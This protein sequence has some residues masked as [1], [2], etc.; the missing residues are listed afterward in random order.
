MIGV[1]DYLYEPAGLAL[2]VFLILFSMSFY[3]F[4]Y[5][6]KNKGTSVLISLILSILASWQLYRERFYGWEETIRFL[7]YVIL[8]V[9]IVKIIWRF[10]KFVGGAF[11]K[12]SSKVREFRVR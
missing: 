8:I 2:G 3:G 12:S 9:F 1:Q 6:M 5:A 4:S 11:K 10:L 7:F